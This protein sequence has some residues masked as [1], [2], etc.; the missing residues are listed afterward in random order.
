VSFHKEGNVVGGLG[1]ELWTT[2]EEVFFSDVLKVGGP[3][4][5]PYG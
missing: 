4:L 1:F 5:P 3:F 2:P